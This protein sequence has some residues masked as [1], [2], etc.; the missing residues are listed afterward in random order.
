[1]AGGTESHST[2]ASWSEMIEKML[3]FAE[4][5]CF[6]CDL[7][8]RILSMHP[9]AFMLLHL[10]THF[11]NPEQVCGHRYLDL[12]A[13]PKQGDI[14][15]Q[16]LQERIAG[17]VDCY[18]TVPQDELRCFRHCFVYQEEPPCVDVL[19]RD[20]SREQKALQGFQRNE[21]QFQELVETV[22][23]VVLRI[24]PEGR[25][26][27]CNT[28]AQ[29]LFGYSAKELMQRSVFETI[30]PAVGTGGQN[31]ET[32]YRDFLTRPEAFPQK[33]I[34]ARRKDDRRLWLSWHN[35][36]FY[37]MAGNLREILVVGTDLTTL[38][39]EQAVQYLQEERRRRITEMVTD[40]V[41]TVQLRDGKPVATTHSRGCKTVT[42][43]AA[44]ELNANPMLWIQMVP[45]E[46]RRLVRE[47]I[48]TLLQSGNAEP[49]EHRVRR[50]D[51][52]LRWVKNTPL[53]YFDQQGNLVA[54]DGLIRDITTE[55]ITDELLRE[56]ERRYRKIT[57]AI[58]DYVYTVRVE[59]G[60]PQETIHSPA[61]EAVTGYS[62]EELQEN[63]YLWIQMV[64]EEDQELV[65]AQAA[66]TLTG[67][68]A[69]PIE[70]RIL[71]KGGR[72]R[73]VLST[74]VP[75]HDSQGRLIAYDGLLRDITLRKEAE[76]ALE[77]QHAL[78]RTFIEHLPDY[79][80][81]KDKRS[82]FILTNPAHLKTLGAQT[83][84]E[85][86]G[87]TDFDFF[88]S[89]LAQEYCADE[90]KIIQTKTPMLNK[91]ERACDREGREY[92]LL[93]S[94]IPVYDSHGVV[95]ALVG[96]SRD[97]TE[98][99]HTEEERR[100]LE[101]K[102]QQARKLESLGI[103]AGGIAHDFNNL[104]MSIL[105][106]VDL[107][108][109]AVPDPSNT[110]TNL[111]EIETAA[112]R[113][114]ELCAKMLAYSG[115]GHFVIEALDLNKV[116]REIHPVLRI[117]IPD[118]V[119]F[120]LEPASHLPQIKGDVT[121]IRQV[122]INFVTNAA[123]AI[124][125]NNGVITV[126]TGVMQCDHDYLEEGYLDDDLVEGPYTYLEVEDNGRGMDIETRER[127]FEP[128]FTT[129]FTGRGLGLAAVLGIMRGHRGA[130]KVES[131]LGQGT[132]FR[133]LF[134]ALDTKHAG[135]EKE[136]RKGSG[137]N[138][139]TILLA[140]DDTAVRI[141]TQM[142]LERKGYALLIAQD[143]QQALEQYQAHKESI[144]A[145]IMDLSMPRLSGLD[146]YNRIRNQ[147]SDI[148]IILTS[149]ASKEEL[150]GP[151]QN[152]TRAAFLQK[153]FATTL[154][155]DTLYNF[156]HP[157]TPREIKEETL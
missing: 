100:A 81:I 39:R 61:C 43:Y 79:A 88:P 123:E 106:N 80:F 67:E 30:V 120:L 135:T 16:W 44:E 4:T 11:E 154:L 19:L 108:M 64:P 69:Q 134:P 115:K 57:E 35:R 63:P 151:I 129:K 90:Q 102:I 142:A 48:A 23:N 139:C 52:A 6:R 131:N 2:E 112:K 22:H 119:H 109:D 83:M 133:A 105:G 148:P 68:D 36:P 156:L 84:D 121:Q 113:A 55:K 117:P 13:Y 18:I 14:F 107:A 94:K 87:K 33:E 124:A 98:R 5:G 26:L 73:W 20:I 157:E 137:K 103:L 65:R 42:G 144:Q 66:A 75:H 99:I 53:T 128:F 47:Q 45:E 9:A 116:L 59:N 58:T 76:E 40:Y 1:M 118:N 3:Q 89:A 56:N 136:G 153:P 85:V 82:R 60:Q 7:E 10:H 37:D 31:L 38:R 72:E 130:I 50:K 91:M 140:D 152:D 78:F 74:H 71:R 93:T 146:L 114:T 77:K 51:G 17:P 86:I 41:Y 95:V 96:I 29:S 110:Y 138:M 21:R 46:D 101:E 104:L 24:T 143:G 97:V 27:Y 111:Q 25:V 141:V 49:I 70:H 32:A 28:F 126:R 54:Y 34:E 149:G 150:P 132:T 125:N 12:V 145:I 147:H 127:L 8:G 62:A 92:I 155:D 15:S 122:I